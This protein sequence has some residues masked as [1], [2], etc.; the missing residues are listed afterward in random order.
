MNVSDERL[1]GAL[2]ELAKAR[3]AE[4]DRSAAPMTFRAIMEERLDNLE[5]QLEE[6]KGRVNGLLFLLAGAVA[7]EIVLRLLR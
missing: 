5:R 1:E 2:E 7:T 6:V 4:Q 3:R